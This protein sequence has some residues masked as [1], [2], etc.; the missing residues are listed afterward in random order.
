MRWIKKKLLIV[1]PVLLFLVLSGFYLHYLWR[2]RKFNQE[3]A[4]RKLIW[5]ALEEKIKANVNDFD[6]DIGLLIK[7][8]ASG[9]E[10]SVNKEKLFPSASLVKVPIMAGV[11]S[12]SAENGLD[13]TSV[14]T[15]NNQCKISGSGVLKNYAAGTEF[16]IERLTEIM[17]TESDNTA[18]NMLI[19]YLGLETLNG[20]FKK[21]GLSHTNLA[22]KMMDFA[23][24]QKGLENYTCAQDLGYLLEQIY[25]NKL[26]NKDFSQKCLE[27]LKKQK[28]KDRIP[29]RLPNNAQVAHKTGLEKY[30]CHDAGIVFTSHGDF[31]ICVLTKHNF[32]FSLPS[33]KFIAEVARNV[34][35]AYQSD[36]MQYPEM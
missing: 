2:V 16:D 25:F 17:I 26:I 11:F 3:L 10:I 5:L 24:R 9:W 23:S 22:R 1:I 19:D 14:L 12:A 4:Q 6:Q 36:K 28:I 33:K 8:C 20:Y 35:C 27:I 34:Y 31:I 18:A 30:V 21:I 29:A 32:K 15:L 13:L 7:D